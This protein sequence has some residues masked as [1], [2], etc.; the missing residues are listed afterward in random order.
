MVRG[1]AEATT[2]Y[3]AV[4][5]CPQGSQQSGRSGTETVTQEGRAAGLLADST[6]AHR[7]ACALE[8]SCRVFTQDASAS[9]GRIQDCYPYRPNLKPKV[10]HMASGWVVKSAAKIWMPL[11]QPTLQVASRDKIPSALV[12][13][14]NRMTATACCCLYLLLSCSEEAGVHKASKRVEHCSGSTSFRH[15]FNDRSC[16]R[17]EPCLLE[18][19]LEQL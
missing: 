11:F 3:N 6:R 8:G 9:I 4:A 18:L 10:L 12:L 14:T 19:D 7:G 1:Q 16:S 2:D 5:K 13:L 15:A 17:H